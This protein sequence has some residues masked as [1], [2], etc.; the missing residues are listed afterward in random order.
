VSEEDLR[1]TIKPKT[2]RVLIFNH[3]AFHEG[4]GLIYY[5]YLFYLFY[6]IL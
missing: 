6:F 4:K 3:E 2:G 1:A 5:F